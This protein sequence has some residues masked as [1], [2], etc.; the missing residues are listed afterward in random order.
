MSKL[1]QESRQLQRELAQRDVEI[2]QMNQSKATVQSVLT[3][4][5]SLKSSS[6]RVREE[7]ENYMRQRSS[8]S[9]MIA[10]EDDGDRECLKKLS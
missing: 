5:T 9:K 2:N 4:P 7:K 10:I 8:L 6:L 1:E 3:N